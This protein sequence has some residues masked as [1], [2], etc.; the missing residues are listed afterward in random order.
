MERL[1]GRAQSFVLGDPL[2]LRQVLL[3]LLGNAIKFTE[4]GRIEVR[5]VAEGVDYDTTVLRFSVSDTGVGIAADKQESVFEAFEQADK[6][7]T[8]KYGGTGLGL[9]I[10]SRLVRIMGGRIWVESTA[11]RGSTFF[12]TVGL[13]REAARVTEGGARDGHADQDRPET[14]QLRIL[15]AEDNPVNMKL[16]TRM[17]EKWG[18]VV[19]PA[20]NGKEALARFKSG[21]FDL[22]LM[23]VQMPEMDGLEAT[24]VIRSQEQFSGGHIPILAMTAHG[25]AEDRDRCL[26]AG[27]DGYVAKPISAATLSG[28]LSAIR[29]SNGIARPVDAQGV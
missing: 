18:H 19:T 1:A 28:A 20:E 3:N 10:C 11:G 29:P 9:A 13:K 17:L 12:F 23:D 26:N 24:A 4:R 27:M 16:A 21:R 15:L 5:V 14:P 8:R 7:T 6:S 2:R 25:Q 22:I